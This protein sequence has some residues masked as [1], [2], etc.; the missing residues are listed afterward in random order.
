MPQHFTTAFKWMKWMMRCV[1]AFLLGMLIWIY[2]SDLSCGRYPSG[3]PWVLFLG[4]A[5]GSWLYSCVLARQSSFLA[6]KPGFNRYAV[7]LIGAT[8]TL[9]VTM[10]ALAILWRIALV[11]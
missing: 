8:V 6:G 3:H 2:W 9:G 7:V 4:M 1:A 5:A 10:F 11:R